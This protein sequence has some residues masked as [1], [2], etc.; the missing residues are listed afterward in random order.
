MRR[1]GH[2]RRCAA[3]AQGKID[4]IHLCERLLQRPETPAERLR[5]FRWPT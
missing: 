3:Q 2:S 1:G 4:V 5:A